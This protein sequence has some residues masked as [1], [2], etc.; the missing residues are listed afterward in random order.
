MKVGFVTVGRNPRPDILTAI[1]KSLSGVQI[2][3][4][5]ALDGLTNLSVSRE[6][7]YTTAKGYSENEQWNGFKPKFFADFHAEKFH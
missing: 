7:R 6:T 1:P 3:E 2:V 5:G 4:T